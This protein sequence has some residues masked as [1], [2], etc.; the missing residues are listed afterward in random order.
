[1]DV[2]VDDD[3]RAAMRPFKEYVVTWSQMQRP[4][5]EAR[6][7]K[8]MAARLEE[9][10]AAGQGDNARVH[11]GEN[12]LAGELWEEAVNA[13]PDEYIDEGWLVGPV[14]RI[15]N[16]VAPWLDCGL[17]GLVVR[18]GPQLTH[19]RMVENLDVFAAIAEAAGKSPRRP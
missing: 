15:A 16:R 10:I 19:D 14:D 8:D 7:Y 13:V 2:L 1:V 6:G 17:T 11:E 3:V 9:L 4:F 5:M 18:Y 12:L